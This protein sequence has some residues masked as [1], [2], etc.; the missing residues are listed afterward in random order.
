MVLRGNLV[1]LMALAAP[2][3]Y[4]K[5]VAVNADGCKV[6]YVKLCKALYGCLKSALLFYKKLWGDLRG[7][8]F[9]MNLYGPCVCNKLVNGTQMTITWHVDDLKISHASDNSIS[10]VIRWLE[11]IYE[12]LDASRGNEHQYLGMDL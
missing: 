7:N 8:G 9:V 1:E 5:Y 10:E 3:T 2:E 4:R 12:K 11:T 6:L